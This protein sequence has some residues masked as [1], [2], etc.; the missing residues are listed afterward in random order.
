MVTSLDLHLGGDCAE[1]CDENEKI[2]R[3]GATETVMQ[4]N[5]DTTCG[6]W[7][8]RGS[9]LQKFA[10]KKSY[11]IL[12]GVLGCLNAASYSYFN[13]TISTVEKRYGIPSKVVGKYKLKV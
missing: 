2:L 7:V 10:N 5:E 11:V 12:F 13:G 4:E 9:F 1:K 8:C 6:F 3:I